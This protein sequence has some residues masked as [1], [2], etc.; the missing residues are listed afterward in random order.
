MEQTNVTDCFCIV[1]DIIDQLLDRTVRFK[2]DS[3]KSIINECIQYSVYTA[4]KNFP[5]DEKVFHIDPNESDNEP[6]QCSSV[7]FENIKLQKRMFMTPPIIIFKKKPR[8]HTKKIKRLNT[9]ASFMNDQRGVARSSYELNKI[10]NPRKSIMTKPILKFEKLISEKDNDSYYLKQR[11][12]FDLKLLREE[13]KKEEE[14]QIAKI[15]KI[16]QDRLKFLRVSKVHKR[17]VQSL[18]KLRSTNLEE[19]ESPQILPKYVVKKPRV[20]GHNY[21]NSSEYRAMMKEANGNLIKFKLKSKQKGSTLCKPPLGINKN[22]IMSTMKIGAKFRKSKLQFMRNK[23]YVGNL[24]PQKGV[25]LKR[26]MANG[27][28]AVCQRFGNI[29]TPQNRRTIGL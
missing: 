17:K 22:L 19:T 21:R 15:K 10:F 13:Q 18:P 28:T 27:R 16:K 26:T 25:T 29:G 14:D 11:E 4:F 6:V 12:L 1:V 23:D 24:T 3:E 5:R 2:K 20:F 9:G 8:R 7:W